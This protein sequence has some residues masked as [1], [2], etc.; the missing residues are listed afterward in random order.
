MPLATVDHPV[1]HL[2]VTE[3]RRVRGRRVG[4]P[5]DD[6]SS[7]AGGTVA[8]SLDLAGIADLAPGGSGSALVATVDEVTDPERGRV[9]PGRHPVD[10]RG[11]LRGAASTGASPGHD[12]RP[13]RPGERRRP[14]GARRR[15]RRRDAAR[16]PRSTTCR[17]SR[18][19][20]ADGVVFI[21]AERTLDRVDD[22]A[23]RRRARPRA[24][25]PGI[26]DPKLYATAGDATT[27]SYDVI[28]VGGD[29][30]KNGPVDQGPNPLPGPGT[31]VAYDEA[32]Q[33]VHILGLAPGRRPR[34]GRGRS[35][36]SSRT[37]TRSTPTHGCPTASCRRPGAP[38]ST[39]TTR[40]RTASS[41]SSSTATGRRPRSTPA[42]TRSPGGSPGSSPVR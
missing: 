12:G 4:R 19:P 28:A 27:P 36:S 39:R 31:L 18:S 21:D 23:G 5:A 33:Q 1:D 17:G 42:R 41:C 11:R 10:R 32:S 7:I 38:T 37:A 20:T 24:W 34:P 6:A 14:D 25:S 29:A 22:R 30:A 35:T 3:R 16:H 13:R 15:D 26:D 9:D 2:L 8:G 40:P